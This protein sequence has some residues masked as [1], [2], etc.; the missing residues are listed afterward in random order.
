MT[1]F[2]LEGI[3]EPQHTDLDNI[4]PHVITDL[5]SF[6][7]FPPVHQGTRDLYYLLTPLGRP[8]CPFLSHWHRTWT[9]RIPH[10]PPHTAEE[11]A[12]SFSLSPA[13]YLRKEGSTSPPHTAEETAVSFSLSLAP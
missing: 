10:S 3:I 5:I 8:L 11:T 9:K 2:A 13:P 12:V 7:A 4:L 6:S 1:S